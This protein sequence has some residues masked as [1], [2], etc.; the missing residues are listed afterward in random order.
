MDSNTQYTFNSRIID[1]SKK[2]SKSK[3]SKWITLLFFLA[4]LAII[5]YIAYTS[6]A[7]QGNIFA[8][9]S[10]VFSLWRKNIKYILLALAMPLIAI[11]IE[12]LKYAILIRHKTGVWNIRL[13]I[14]TT[15]MGKYYDNITP[16]SS[17]GQPFQIFYLKK[18][19]VPLGVATGL[20][21]ITFFLN[22]LALVILAI[23]VMIYLSVHDLGSANTAFNAIR[24]VAYIGTITSIIVPAAIIG[25]SIM[26]KFTKKVADFIVKIIYKLKFVRHKEKYANILYN[27]LDDYQKSMSQ[28]KKSGFVLFICFVL[29]FAYKFALLSTPYFILRGCGVTPNYFE[30]FA[31]ILILT[32]SVSFI[33]TPGNS[34]ASELSFQALFNDTLATMGLGSVYTFWSMLYWRVCVY[35]MFIFLG[36]IELSI[37]SLKHKRRK[38]YNPEPVMAT[39]YQ[40]PIHGIRVLHKDHSSM[41]IP[42]NE[43]EGQCYISDVVASYELRP[44]K[45]LTLRNDQDFSCLTDNSY[46]FL[47][48]SCVQRLIAKLDPTKLYGISFVVDK[49]K[50]LGPTIEVDTGKEKSPLDQNDVR[51]ET[52]QFTDVY[53]PLRGESAKHV[54]DY[55]RSL[56]ED[57]YATRVFVPKYKLKV[58]NYETKDYPLIHAPSIRFF[59]T[60]YVWATPNIRI[61]L[62]LSLEPNGA[63]LVFHAQTPFFMGKYALKM[64]RRYDVPIV[65]SFR[66]PFYHKLKRS[67]HSRLIAKLV[68]LNGLSLYKRCDAVFVP[69][70][71]SKEELR[72][73]G[74][75]GPV[76]VVS[77]AYEAYDDE[78]IQACKEKEKQFLKIQENEKVLSIIATHKKEKEEVLDLLVRLDEFSKENTVVMVYGFFAKERQKVLKEHRFQHLRLLLLN[79]SIFVE[80]MIQAS[81]L[82]LVL[83]DRTGAF[84]YE[85]VAAQY[86][87]PTFVHGIEHL[88]IYK[89]NEN[90]FILQDDKVVAAKE[91]ASILEK[92]EQRKAVGEKAHATLTISKEENVKNIERA[93]REVIHRY[94]ESV[95]K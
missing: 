75:K 30:I 19:G 13:G 16:L 69:S 76:M 51:I 61:P 1:P 94:Y 71:E 47:S 65:V 6:F 31:K 93:Y 11:L 68:E 85:R 78:R 74:Y 12:G 63:L 9:S 84:P 55:A 48:K 41:L 17:G 49:N 14:R 8:S 22:Q 66:H 72:K 21:F 43:D 62:K 32:V 46:V 89:P 44:K 36:I 25:V 77:D 87:I 91:L 53:Y 57:G 58:G 18:D 20:P 23:T 60:P 34:G 83:R 40:V 92:D 5:A 38:A 24:I 2:K 7:G 90:C 95:K 4:N 10:V 88:E 59:F 29:S 35:F 28:Y 37:L 15:I 56:N 42:L 45:P 80:E 26:P 86:K 3:K 79:H 54:E 73:K 27:T 64:A 33:P 82:L 52:V 70:I 81:D 67:L 39:L 50:K